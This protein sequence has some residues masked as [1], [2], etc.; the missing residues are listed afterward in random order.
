MPFLRSVRATQS[1]LKAAGPE[2]K[3]LFLL[4]GV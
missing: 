2:F 3:D 1:I 4:E